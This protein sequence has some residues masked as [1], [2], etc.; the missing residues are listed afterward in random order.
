MRRRPV[1]VT[2]PIARPVAR[3]V[4]V[5]SVLALTG[6]WSAPAEQPPSS[7]SSTSSPW[8]GEAPGSAQGTLTLAFAGDVHFEGALA[9]LLE[10]DGATLG[11]MAPVLARADLAMV[12]LESAIARGGRRTRKE[13]E[14]PADRHW[15]RSPPS[16][17]DL[18][19]RSGVD[20]VT[21]A[22]NHGADR[23]GAGLEETLAAA[24]GAPLA[25]VGVGADADGAYA[26]H[27][28]RIGGTDVA[29]LAADASTLE[30]ADPFWTAGEEHAGIASA[31]EDPPAR[32]VAAVQAAD[33]TDDLVVVY[34]HWGR[35]EQRCPTRDQ[36]VLAQTL[37]SAG[38]DVVVGSHAHVLLGAG[39]LRRPGTD[40]YVA[41]GLG[42]FVWY[43]GRRPRTGVLE[44]VVTDGR[45]VADRLVPARIP[46]TGG[47]PDA[48]T[49]Q[50]RL[51]A[52][53][54]W[55]GLR[56][57]T[58][59][60]AVESGDEVPADGG[61]PSYEALV[62]ELGPSLRRRLR[63]SHGPACPV[64]LDDLRHLRLTH[65]GFDGRAHTGELVVHA[66]HAAD[67]VAVF[68]ELYDARWPVR[69]MRLVSDYGGDDDRSMAA[70]NTSAYNC[71]RVAGQERWS[72]HAHGAAIDLNPV[73]NP[74]VVGDEVRPPAGRRF[75]S[76][77]RSAGAG[78]GPGVI[79]AGD[80]VTRAF[81]RIGWTWG[82]TFSEPDYQHFSAR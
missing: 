47:R 25:V 42:D 50:A 75:A 73:E 69:R 43:H 34:L 29:V 15:F 51:D 78:S 38:A 58:G 11:A 2:R 5:L 10:E 59:L 61:L 66:D 30:S 24:S 4:A 74:Y 13:L 56:G 6:C 33:R 32:L 14:D 70:D 27:R 20:V 16:A 39:M 28:V 40:A 23:G 52:L 48:V 80:V 41:Y 60:T 72:A 76:V 8:S 54:E 63:S 21:V 36:R 67:L 9:G 19:A 12:N 81:E 64:G 3:L 53:A 62:R 57:C 65:V 49:G 44:V 7:P 45:V 79:T 22:N 31:R 46:R 17:L 26:P 35:A 37:A 82:G 71:R 68:E 55:E 77:D 18:L 1:T